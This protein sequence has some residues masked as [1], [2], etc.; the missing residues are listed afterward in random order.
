MYR[1]LLEAHSGVRY[2]V[3]LALVGAIIFSFA[4]WFGG[5]SFTSANKRINLI[6][7]ISTHVQ[8]VLGLILYFVSSYVN[9]DDMGTTMKSTVLRYWTVEHAVMMI[10]AV[11]LITVGYSKSKKAL[12]DLAKHKTVAIFYSLGLLIII[13]AIGLSGRPIIGS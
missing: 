3:M 13:I 8:L 5:K 10:I 2:L 6:A 11:A 7:L 1:F 9:L 12:N 4:G